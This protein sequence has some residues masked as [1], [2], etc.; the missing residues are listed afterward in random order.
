[1]L[2]LD[3]PLPLL[4]RLADGLWHQAMAHL[5]LDYG[6]EHDL[7]WTVFV[8]ETRECWTL[9]NRDVRAQDNVTAG[10]MPRGALGNGGSRQQENAG[11]R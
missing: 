5:V 6:F 9:R 2:R 10:R 1:M 4:V 3:P 7:A 8:D 11:G